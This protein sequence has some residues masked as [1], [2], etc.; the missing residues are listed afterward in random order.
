MIDRKHRQHRKFLKLLQPLDNQNKS[1][2]FI[3]LSLR[4]KEHILQLLND[5]F[6]K[7]KN[8]NEAIHL[9]SLQS[10]NYSLIKIELRFEVY[11]FRISFSI[12]ILLPMWMLKCSMSHKLFDLLLFLWNHSLQ[13]FLDRTIKVVHYLEYLLLLNT[14]SKTFK[15]FVKP[16]NTLLLFQKFFLNF[17]LKIKLKFNFFAHYHR[18]H[19]HF[20]LIIEL[21]L[22]FK[23]FNTLKNHTL[24]DVFKVYKY[25]LSIPNFRYL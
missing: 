13:Y 19:F 10:Y 4:H 14:V 17:I 3:L 23:F 2:I 16:S 15:R 20:N 7:R 6:L 11:L 21:N 24:D 1:Y 25:Q 8:G 12:W 18:Y 5:P 22:K 9:H